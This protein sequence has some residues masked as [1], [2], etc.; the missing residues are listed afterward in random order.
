M[1]AG[2]EAAGT[3]STL[4]GVPAGAA[5]LTLESSCHQPSVVTLTFSSESSSLSSSG[6][7]SFGSNRGSGDLGTGTWSRKLLQ[8]G[9]SDSDRQPQAPLPGQ[10]PGNSSGGDKYDPFAPSQQD[11][12]SGMGGVGNGTS[13]GGT[14]SGGNATGA[15]PTD[16]QACCCRNQNN[17]LPYQPDVY[18]G[19]NC[20]CGSKKR[21]CGLRAGAVAAMLPMQS[22]PR[23]QPLLSLCLPA[24]QT[25][26]SVHQFQHKKCNAYLHTCTGLLKGAPT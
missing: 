22:C 14:S 17:P 9:A 24:H 4:D 11:M 21:E 18:I 12:G 5:Y 8:L 3:I 20:C 25:T 7:S 13:S 16:D 19:S 26:G 10:Q 6:S 2:G 15:T 23:W 1:L